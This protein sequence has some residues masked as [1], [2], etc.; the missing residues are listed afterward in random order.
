MVVCPHQCNNAHATAD[1]DI[2]YE[3]VI[4]TFRLRD[5]R[6]VCSHLRRSCGGNTHAL[7]CLRN[8]TVATLFMVRAQL[9]DDSIRWR[10]D[11]NRW[12]ASGDIEYAVGHLHDIRGDEKAGEWVNVP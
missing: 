11:W 1:I 3:R 4:S 5:A 8:A 2:L 6:V 10:L 7:V 9:Q 12:D